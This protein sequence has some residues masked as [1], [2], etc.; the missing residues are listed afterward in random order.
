MTLGLGGQ[1]HTRELVIGILLS[2]FV[3]VGY[4]LARPLRTR[5]DTGHV[6]SSILLVTA[7][8]AIALLIQ[9]ALS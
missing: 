2:P 9:T 1:L 8:S 5:I 4:V 7:A 3:V 6:R